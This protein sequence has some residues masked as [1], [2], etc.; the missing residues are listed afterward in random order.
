MPPGFA[1]GVGSF[2]FWNQNISFWHF[3]LNLQSRKSCGK[4]ALPQRR[5]L[6]TDDISEEFMREKLTQLGFQLDGDMIT[7]PSYRADVEG[8]GTSGAHSGQ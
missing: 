8:T 1:A 6:G 4:N 5:F 3:I 7:V 2:Q